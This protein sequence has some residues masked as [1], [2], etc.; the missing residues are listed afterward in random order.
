MDEWINDGE[1]YCEQ[2]DIAFKV[3]AKN[4]EL[5]VS[6]CPGCSSRRIKAVEED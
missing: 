4:E 5:T 2:C 3:Y 6:F 1:W